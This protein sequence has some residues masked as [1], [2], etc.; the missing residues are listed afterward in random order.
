MGNT[1]YIS[2]KMYIIYHHKIKEN[3]KYSALHKHI[4][5]KVKT[6]SF[7]T[8]DHVTE[9]KIQMR[10]GPVQMQSYPYLK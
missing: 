9:S 4:H 8:I 7:L 6:H 3:H 5:M 10:N 2:F 1:N